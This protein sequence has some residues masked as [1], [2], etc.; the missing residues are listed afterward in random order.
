MAKQFLYDQAEIQGANYAQPYIAPTKEY[1]GTIASDLAETGKMAVTDHQVAG[2][3]GDLQEVTGEFLAQGDMEGAVKSEEQADSKAT[4]E[5]FSEEGGLDDI[6]S[7]EK[8]IIAEAQRGADKLRQA[9][10]QGRLTGDAFRA[11]TEAMLKSYINQTPGLSTELRKIA[12]STLGFDPTGSALDAALKADKLMQVSGQKRIA[13]MGKLLRDEGFISDP[14]MS[15]AEGIARYWPVRSE[16]ELKHNLATKGLATLKASE[17]VSD[18]NVRKV[19]RGDVSGDLLS[20]IQDVKATLGI[21]NITPATLAKLSDDERQDMLFKL[22]QYRD[23]KLSTLTQRYSQISGEV[24]DLYKGSFDWIDSTEKWLN[25]ELPSE[26]YANTQAASINRAKADLVKDPHNAAMFAMFDALPNV[27]FSPELTLLVSDHANILMKSLLDKKASPNDSIEQQ[28]EAEG[29][30]KVQA[31]KLKRGFE[32]QLMQGWR[33]WKDTMTDS[34][35][36]SLHTTL[37]KYTRDINGYP[38]EVD[39]GTMDNLFEMGVDPKFAELVY[40]GGDKQLNLN[41]QEVAKTYVPRV[42]SSLNA[43]MKAGPY[44]MAD[45]EAQILGSGEIR[46]I[47]SPVGKRDISEP[48][49][50][51]PDAAALVKPHVDRAEQKRKRDIENNAVRLNEIYGERLNNVVKSVAHMD[52]HTKYDMVAVN[53]LASDMLALGN[54]L[55]PALRERLEAANQ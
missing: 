13:Q 8:G 29:L 37:L 3:Q 17:D 10:L 22:Q 9:N 45:Y 18:I 19:A 51:N 5:F 49:K 30:T 32:K 55:A 46:F 26:L 16:I 6:T 52:G 31:E 27:P 12:A 54:S 1:V 34:D 2:L 21:Q 28:A 33:K 40:H 7:Q 35:K 23:V 43:D 44:D 25:N 4:E 53:L 36:S 48:S 50:L 47:V 42:F 41:L 24:P 39:T 15:D 20:T 38:N 11:K 14:N